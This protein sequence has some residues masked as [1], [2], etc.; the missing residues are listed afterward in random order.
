M[1][2]PPPA[3]ALVLFHFAELL[4]HA[5]DI[6]NHLHHFFLGFDYADPMTQAQSKFTLPSLQAHDTS[7]TWSDEAKASRLIRDES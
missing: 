1:V 2:W 5:A 7:K 4:D 3:A 6:G